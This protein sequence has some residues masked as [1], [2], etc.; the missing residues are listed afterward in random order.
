MEEQKAK[1][2]W[3]KTAISNREKIAIENYPYGYSLKTTMFDSVEFNPKKGFRHVRQTINP[4]TGKLNA[5]K[6]STYYPFMMRFMD[7]EGHIKTYAHD[8]N[9]FEYMNEGAEILNKVFH[10]LNEAE[11]ES[12]YLHFLFM[13]KVS[14]KA[15]IIYCNSE[16]ELLRPLICEQVDLIK[17]GLKTGENEYCNFSLDLEKIQSLK[18]PNFKP[19]QVKE[20]C[21][22]IIANGMQKVAK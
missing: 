18:D 14:C 7:H 21:I 9:G 15:H 6:K 13:L 3:T 12:L 20:T 4:K 1:M 22:N 2:D 5:E 17:K 16:W 19:F 11:K 10:L 8:F